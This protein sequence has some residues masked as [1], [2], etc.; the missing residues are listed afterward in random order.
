MAQATCFA[1]LRI[2]RPGTSSSE[3]TERLGIT[4]T[5]SHEAGDI[6]RSGH[7]RKGAVWGLST[8]HLGRGPLTEHLSALLEQVENRREVLRD[9]SGDGFTM[10]WFCFVDVDGMGGVDLDA[11]LLARLGTFP[12]HLD[13]DIYGMEHDEDAPDSV[14][15]TQTKLD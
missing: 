11:D 12:I 8:E 2:W 4:P 10:D 3:I 7:V 14:N 15:D 13:L 9:L 5:F 6:G 1:T